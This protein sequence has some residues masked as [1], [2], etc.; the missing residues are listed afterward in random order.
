MNL[1]VTLLPKPWGLAVLDYAFGIDGCK[2]RHIPE[3]HDSM[4]SEKIRSSPDLCVRVTWEGTSVGHALPI[5]LTVFW[6]L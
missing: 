4:A 2:E 5:T 6:C 1:G 3:K